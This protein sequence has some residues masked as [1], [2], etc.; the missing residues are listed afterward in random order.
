MSPGPEP[1][2]SQASWK[3]SFGTGTAARPV[4]M[5]ISSLS[6]V[7]F[8]SPHRIGGKV[9]G[10]AS[11]MNWQI[12]LTCS[13]RTPD[14]SKRQFRWVRE[15]LQRPVGRVDVDPHARAQLL[16]VLGGRER[17]HLGPV[18]G[19]RE[20]DR[21]AEADP[22]EIEPVAAAVLGTEHV[23]DAAG[24]GVVGALVDPHLLQAGDVGIEALHGVDDRRKPVL[25]RPEPPPQVP[26]QDPEA[27]AGERS[28]GGLGPG[29]EPGVCRFGDHGPLA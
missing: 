13:W 14:W 21:V 8:M 2:T 25:P 15:D 23:G 17:E 24:G 16:G 22:V 6:G 26:G 4:S 28:V 5:R 1:A 29:G 3:T 10:G 27:A 18:I 20:H 11:A 19:H 7:A 12:A 9:R